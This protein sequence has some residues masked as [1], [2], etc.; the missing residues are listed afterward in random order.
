MP[1][2]FQ[3]GGIDGPHGWLLLEGAFVCITASNNMRFSS[4]IKD[5][6]VVLVEASRVAGERRESPADETRPDGGKR[7]SVRP[8]R[9]VPQLT[10]AAVSGSTDDRLALRLLRYRQLRMVQR[11]GSRPPVAQSA[12][13]RHRQGS[14][15][16]DVESRRS[17]PC[18]NE[19][20]SAHCCNDRGRRMIDAI[21]GTEL[22]AAAPKPPSPSAF[23]I[24]FVIKSN[25]H[26]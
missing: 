8:A 25:F 16:T 19:A 14:D 26:W 9:K 1:R 15:V 4:S 17:T 24:E 20:A 10:G 7:R 11:H 6:C 5:S 13:R 18:K 12:Y 21:Q 3:A 22:P 2:G 23:V